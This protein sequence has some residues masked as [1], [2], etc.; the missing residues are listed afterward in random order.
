MDLWVHVT[1]TTISKEF[2]YQ[3]TK[4]FPVLQIQYSQTDVFYLLKDR[5][6]NLL[7]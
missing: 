1:D 6:P 5:L 3:T 4:P 2:E 7:R